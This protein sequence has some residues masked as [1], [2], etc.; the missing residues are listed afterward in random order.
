MGAT[1]GAGT[2]YPSRA[3]AFSPDFFSGVRVTR[4]FI[5]YVCFVDRYFLF[6]FLLICKFDLNIQNLFIIIYV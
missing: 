5:L 1:S 3:P 6:V 4:S 2:V